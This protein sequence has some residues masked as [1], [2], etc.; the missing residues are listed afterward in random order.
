M[1]DRLRDI[2]AC[3]GSVINHHIESSVIKRKGYLCGFNAAAAVDKRVGKRRKLGISV[4]SVKIQ[5]V[6]FC[7][8]ADKHTH[9]ILFA[10]VAHRYSRRLPVL[11]DFV[12][13][14]ADRE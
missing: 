8:F 12:D 2:E 11:S 14:H 4:L 7:I 13:V 5:I 3:N 6:S 10:V 9:G 1:V